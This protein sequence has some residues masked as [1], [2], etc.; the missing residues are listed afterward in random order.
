MNV[1][2]QPHKTD[3]ERALSPI[4][5]NITKVEE[6]YQIRWPQKVTEISLGIGMDF[7]RTIRAWLSEYLRQPQAGMIDESKP[8]TNQG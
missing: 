5:I 8:L 1:K 3:D 2:E 4:N 7:V 6:R